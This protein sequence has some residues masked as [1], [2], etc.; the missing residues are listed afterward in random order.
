MMPLR[1]VAVLL[2]LAVGIEGAALRSD[3]SSAEP[4]TAPVVWDPKDISMSP[5]KP[6]VTKTG[7][8]RKL[9]RQSDKTQSILKQFAAL[10]ATAEK[11]QALIKKLMREVQSLVSQRPNVTQ[12]TTSPAPDST[13]KTHSSSEENDTSTTEGARNDEPTTPKVSLH[14][15]VSHEHSGSLESSSE[16]NDQTG[17]AAPTTQTTSENGV[18]ENIPEHQAVSRVLTTE[19]AREYRPEATTVAHS[20]TSLMAEL[21]EEAQVTNEG[22]REDDAELLTS[23]TGSSGFTTASQDGEIED[24]IKIARGYSMDLTTMSNAIMNVISKAPSKDLIK[25]VTTKSGEEGVKATTR[26]ATAA[27]IESIRMAGQE[28]TTKIFQADATDPSTTQWVDTRVKDATEVAH[29]DDA[30][31]TPAKKPQSALEDGGEPALNE[32]HTPKE[33]KEASTTEQARSDG[34]TDRSATE[35]YSTPGQLDNTTSGSVRSDNS[36]EVTTHGVEGSDAKQTTVPCTTNPDS[37]EARSGS[38]IGTCGTSVESEEQGAG[39]QNMTSSA[40]SGAPGW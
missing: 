2:A 18:Y 10:A 8:L 24:T 9:F 39:E 5:Q 35:A 16:E 12:A 7:E 34:G 40:N 33:Q 29:Q 36:D 20:T 19:G 3:E 21:N 32:K 28:P 13:T 4:Y 25:A 17:T 1:C 38:A 11:N 23:T 37:E 31:T 15:G 6:Y 14:A 27:A 22:V 26:K 30:E